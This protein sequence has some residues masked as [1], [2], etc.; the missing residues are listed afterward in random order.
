M[1]AANV[2][3]QQPIAQARSDMI[4][5]RECLSF[6]GQIGAAGLVLATPLGTAAELGDRSRMPQRVRDVIHDYEEQGFH[7]TGTAVDRISGEWLAGQVREIGLDPM[8]DDFEL[9][10]VDPIDASVIVNGRKIEGLPLFDGGFTS[11]EGIR[12]RMGNLNSDAPIGLTEIA[13]NAADS[14]ALGEAR[15]QGRHLAIVAVTHGD[16]PGFCPS[17]A[18]SFRHPFGPPVLQVSSEEA[19]FLVDCARQGLQAMLTAHVE[20]AQAQ[21]FNVTTIISGTKKGMAP[22]VVMTP[23]SGWWSCASE[24]GGGI[25]CWLE[26][27]RAMRD[28]R[29]RRDI[30]FVASSGHEIGYRGI[31]V[32]ID[33][34]PEIVKGARG[35][36]HLGANI[37]AAQGSGNLLQASDDE[38]EM[39]IAEAMMM[40]GLQVNRRAPRGRVPAGEAGNV[41]RGGGRYLSVIGRNELFHNPKDRGPEAV[42]LRVMVRFAGALAIVTKTLATA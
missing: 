10:R 40:A 39:I 36:I 9:S 28:A 14:G 19:P 31:E 16:R 21:S 13:P 35:W 17:N 25:A 18:D 29:P 11:S 30:L 7:R 1:P 27:M 8:L 12:G 34:Q 38:M 41:H 3:A 22:V 37:G 2:G 32:F 23:R 5:R 4:A 26:I 15:R 42:D 6:V 20:R 24:R 33:R